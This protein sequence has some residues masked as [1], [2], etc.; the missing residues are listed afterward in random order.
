[1]ELSQDK[2]GIVVPEVLHSVEPLGMVRF[3]VEFYKKPD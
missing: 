3:L 2:L 1:M